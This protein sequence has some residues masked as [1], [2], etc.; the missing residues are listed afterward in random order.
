MKKLIAA[1]LAVLMLFSPALAESSGD[2][3][4]VIEEVILDEENPEGKLPEATEA[5][6]A[7]E[8]TV[9]TPS[10]GSPY[11][12]DLGSSYWTL[13]MDI[14]D[15]EAVWKMLMEPMTVVRIGS[16]N[17]EKKQTYLYKEPDENSK[18]VGVVTRDSQGV[19]VIEKLDSGWSLVECYSSSFH[20]TKVK[21]WNMLVQGY[22][23]TEYLTQV[24]P[25]PN[26][27]IV[28]DK[29][30]QRLYIFQDGK[31]LTTL[32]CSTGLVQHNGSKWQPYNETRSGEFMLMSKVGTLKSDRL[33]CDMAIRF[34]S[35][36]MVHEVPHVIQA[37][38]KTKNYNSTEPKLGT[39]C[40]HGCIR[41]QRNKTPEGINM[42]WL[43]NQVKSGSRVK[44]VIWE[45][46]QGRQIDYP[47][48]DTVL[49][50]NP[51][52]GDYYHRAETCYM[53]KK[54]TFSP[55]TYAELDEGA[56]AKLKFCPYCGP[57]LR[58]AEIDAINERYAEGGDHDENLTMLRQE[59]EQYMA[60]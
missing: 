14:T 48:P 12:S 33:L 37:D 4:L 34:N 6:A 17:Q 28:V 11:S 45:D 36:D 31:L 41:V 2:G 9:F 43:W 25:N 44:F 27:G 55:F 51:N 29:L 47:D 58:T 5:P 49:Y 19:R 23:K 3:D 26:L 52:G 8:K 40:S 1:A 30:T 57:A 7:A 42:G 60:E 16:G 24:Q 54:L 18:K 13:P 53:A 32:L 50:Y 21:A 15:E 20:D 22:I 56:F 59:Y 10:Y 39:K 38:G 46:W 35:G